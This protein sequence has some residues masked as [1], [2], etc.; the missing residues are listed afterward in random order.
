[1]DVLGNGVPFVF[2]GVMTVATLILTSSM[3]KYSQPPVRRIPE[4]AHP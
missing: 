1:M 3:E 4:P 2:A